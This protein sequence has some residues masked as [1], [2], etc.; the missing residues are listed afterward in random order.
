MDIDWV[1][2]TSAIVVVVVTHRRSKEIITL[3]NIFNIQY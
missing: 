3:Q 1:A 2:E